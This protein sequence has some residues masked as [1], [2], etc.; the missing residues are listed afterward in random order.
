MRG[1][2]GRDAVS[3]G[4]EAVPSFG[5]RKLRF[6]YRCGRKKAIVVG[7]SSSLAHSPTHS[8]SLAAMRVGWA[9]SCDRQPRSER[10]NEWREAAS[11]LCQTYALPEAIY[12]PTRPRPTYQPTHHHATLFNSTHLYARC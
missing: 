4:G 7:L 10:A 8:L 11:T 3:H 2:G 6:E 1:L 5:L 12:L 9:I